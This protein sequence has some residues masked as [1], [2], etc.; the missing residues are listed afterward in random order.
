MSNINIISE[1]DNSTVITKYEGVNSNNTSYQSESQLEN[2]FIKTL[3]EQG[4]ERLYIN[5]EEELIS[6]LRK[7]LERLNKYNFSDNEWEYL[8]KNEIAKVTQIF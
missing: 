8:F 3:C 7:Q 4:Y 1:N 2:E 5:S 6:N